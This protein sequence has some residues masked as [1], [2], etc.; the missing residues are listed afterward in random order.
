MKTLSISGSSRATV[1][2]K[3]TTALRKEGL[4]PCCIYGEAKDVNGN[5]ISKAFTVTAERKETQTM[6]NYFKAI[7]FKYLNRQELKRS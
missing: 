2:K 6:V 1:G 5:P 3:S 4:V 7:Q